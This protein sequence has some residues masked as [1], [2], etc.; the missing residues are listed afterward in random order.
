MFDA[1]F[2]DYDDTIV[3]YSQS[4]LNEQI[5]IEWL[6]SEG[7]PNPKLTFFT[8]RWRDMKQRLDMLG[9]D[10]ITYRTVIRPRFQFVELEYKKRLL[11]NGRMTLNDGVLDFLDDSA[12]PLALISNSSPLVLNYFLDVFG[13]EDLFSYIYKRK[14]DLDDVIKP[15]KCIAD[16]ALATLGLSAP[17]R[18]AMIGDSDVDV[19]FAR[20]AN[21]FSIN[22]FTVQ[23]GCDLHF[24]GFPEMHSYFKDDCPDCL[25]GGRL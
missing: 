20:N 13:I 4:N 16:E 10:Y 19:R 22:L 6:S 23:E 18:V 17:G 5:M 24:S 1:F 25:K 7:I 12:V 3:R 15:D 9:T 2:L 21:L 11:K 8:D 14:Y